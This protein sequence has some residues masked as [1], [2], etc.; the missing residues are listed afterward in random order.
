MTID[1]TRARCAWSACDYSRIHL[2]NT[3]IF[4]RWCIME[5]ALI[6]VEYIPVMTSSKDASIFNDDIN[7]YPRWNG[8]LPN[9]IHNI[10]TLYIDLYTACCTAAVCPSYFCIAFNMVGSENFKRWSLGKPSHWLAVATMC[11]IIWTICWRRLWCHYKRDAIPLS[12]FVY[13]PLC[14]GVANFVAA[15][16]ITNDWNLYDF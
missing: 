12:I 15:A 6:H 11:G 16:T 5:T 4:L 9:R 2:I 1:C 7:F 13:L 8:T 14:I 10:Q 3:K